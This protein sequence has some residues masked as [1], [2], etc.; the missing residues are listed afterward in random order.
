VKSDLPVS[1][2]DAVIDVC[3]DKLNALCRVDASVFVIVCGMLSMKFVAVLMVKSVE[4]GFDVDSV[5]SVLG[6][7]VNVAVIGLEG[8]SV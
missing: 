3:G 8:L 6:V 5:K 2:R 7:D 4:I 1:V